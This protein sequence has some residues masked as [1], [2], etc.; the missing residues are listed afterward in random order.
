M[1]KVN[2]EVE[3]NYVGNKAYLSARSNVRPMDDEFYKG[4]S[5]RKSYLAVVSSSNLD[6]MFE[7]LEKIS[8]QKKYKDGVSFIINGMEFAKMANNKDT[9]SYND[10]FPEKLIN[11]Y[12]C[13][14][15]L[16][17]KLELG[18]DGLLSLYQPNQFRII[19]GQGVNKFKNK[20]GVGNKIIS[21]ISAKLKR[22]EIDGNKNIDSY[23]LELN[24]QGKKIKLGSIIKGQYFISQRESVSNFIKGLEG[25]R[26]VKKV[27]KPSIKKSP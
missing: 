24:N 5:P 12:S 10:D 11:Q 21:L 4:S 14:N 18:E 9:L 7:S 20:E 8:Q 22:D 13:G 16:V 15:K 17:F 2:L 19:E 27:K 6:Q 25:N 1:I 26:E 3:R 23:Q